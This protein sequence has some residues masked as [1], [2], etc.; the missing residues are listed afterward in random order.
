MPRLS[1]GMLVSLG[2]ISGPTGR[3]EASPWCSWAAGTVDWRE[4]GGPSPDLPPSAVMAAADLLCMWWQYLVPEFQGSSDVF[5]V[6]CHQAVVLRAWL[7]CPTHH[8][9]THLQS[10]ASHVCF[11]KQLAYVTRVGWGPGNLGV[12]FEIL[13]CSSKL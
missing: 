7:T 8:L 11:L 9:R 2:M 13:P 3:Q 5:A 10:S 6:S 1:W 12:H 4:A